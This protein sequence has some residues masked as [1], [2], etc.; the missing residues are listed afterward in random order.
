MLV[1]GYCEAHGVVRRASFLMNKRSG[2]YE[3]AIRE[4]RLGP[5]RIR[6]GAPL[7]DFQGI[8]SGIPTS[9]VA[10]ALTPPGAAND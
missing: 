8:L 3:R 4:L 2:G 5:D 10:P 6:V 9:L 7:T 1:L